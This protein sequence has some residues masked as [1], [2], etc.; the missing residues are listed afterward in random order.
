MITDRNAGLRR[1]AGLLVLAGGLLAGPARAQNAANQAPSLRWVPAN[2]AGYSALLRNREQ[3]D[4]VLHSKA[5]ARLNGLPLVQMAR[6]MLET[7][8]A[9]PNGPLAT[10]RN[11]YEQPD[12]ADLIRFVGELLSDEVFVYSG[13]NAADFALLLGEVQ[14]AN[15][16]APLAALAQGGLPA[17]NDPGMRVRALLQALSDNA[18]LITVPELVVGF[19]LSRTT[20]AQAA[21]RLVGLEKA[22]LQAVPD[23]RKYLKKSKIDGAEVRSLVL[24]GSLI[25]WDQIPIQQ[26]EERQGQF[27]KLLNRLKGMKLTLA[28]S[29]RGNYL[30]FSVG[31]GTEGLQDVAEG[32]PNRLSDRP[33]MAALSKAAGRRL[34]SI[35]YSSKEYQAA[36]SGG[37]YVESLAGWARESLKTADLPA[38]KKAKL[39]QQLKALA[40]DAKRLAPEPGAHLAF[41]FLTDQGGEGYSYDWTK[42]RGQDGGKPLTLLQHV[43]G[44]PVAFALHR[45]P[46][47]VKE[48]ELLSRAVRLGRQTF[49]EIVLPQLPFPEE[50]KDLYRQFMTEAKPLFARFDKATSQRLLPA[51]DGQ[52]GFVLDARLKSQQWHQAM[53]PAEKPLPLPEPAVVLGVRDPALFRQAF[54]EYRE[55]FNGLMEVVAKVA[56][57]PVPEIKIP[58]PQVKK[59][60]VGTFYSYPFPEALGLDPKL[61]LTCGLSDKVAVFTLSHDHAKR[62]LAPTAWQGKGGPL[63]DRT[64]PLVGAAYFDCPALMDAA[65]PWVEYAFAQAGQGQDVLDQVKTVMQILKV[66]RSYSS[67][68]YPEEG[69]TVTHNRT[70]IRDLE[71]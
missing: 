35:T 30:L 8:W 12:N 69:A 32:S 62:L 6:Q 66:F 38:D 3:I 24:E 25:P 21:K 11:W 34:T 20:P 65:A 47:S 16:L 7:Q 18:K 51:L 52:G 68:T 31:E 70:V 60:D 43:G 42:V 54:Q 28:F 67:A 45:D 58:D 55:V 2:A 22:M 36:V 26:F 1:A 61:A 10:V 4:A 44:R 19:R 17:L 41:G 33:E 23:V 48:Y 37:H 64:R 27:D 13:K 9:N 71:K 15:Q 46:V 57:V 50:F 40:A 5:W 63:N 29:V 56:P 49:D 59:T 39:E 53:P 14:A